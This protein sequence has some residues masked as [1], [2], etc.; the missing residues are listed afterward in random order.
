M[1]SLLWLTKREKSRTVSPASSKLS[2]ME[3]TSSNAY[4]SADRNVKFGSRTKP[5]NQRTVRSFSC[6]IRCAEGRWS[7]QKSTRSA[8]CRKTW[9]GDLLAVIVSLLSKPWHFGNPDSDVAIAHSSLAETLIKL[10][11]GLV[12]IIAA[13]LNHDSC[14]GRGGDNTLKLDYKSLINL[15]DASRKEALQSMTSLYQRLSHSQLQLQLSSCE[16]CGSASHSNCSDRGSNVEK[17][18]RKRTSSRKHSNG[19]IVTRMPIKSSSEPQLVFVRSKSTKK[20]RSDSSSSSSKSASS[21]AYTS[22]LSS[23][24]PEYAVLDP[25]MNVTPDVARA[26]IGGG[27]LTP[28]IGRKRIDSL[29]AARPTNWQPKPLKHGYAVAPPANFDFPTTKLPDF[30]TTIRKD[31]PSPVLRKPVP[32]RNKASMMSS[33]PLPPSPPIR[34][35]I[36]KATPSSYTFASDSTK[37]GEIPQ[38]NWMTPWDYEEAD[39]LNAEAAMAPAP[40]IEEKIKVKKG[41]FKFLR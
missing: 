2:Q 25:F 40:V 1:A 11:T 33:P 9:G 24:V 34:R 17:D 26:T 13:F 23:P 5:S 36:D 19:R 15:S 6:R 37:L 12:G 21:S 32:Q 8:T 27:N 22:P 16:K 41:L 29:D 7:W 35:R 14:D 20:G 39:R 28:S 31:S 18:K 10:N 3:S 30:T 4:A 38:R